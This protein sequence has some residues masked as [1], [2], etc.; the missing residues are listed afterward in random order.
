VADPHL[1]VA[2]TRDPRQVRLPDGSLRTPPPDWEFLPAGDAGL[3]RRVKKAGPVWVVQERHGRRLIARG[4]WAPAA[5]VAIARAE[6][7]LERSTPAYA[8][9]LARAAERRDREQSAYVEEFAAEVRRFLAFA[10]GFGDH[11][12]RLAEAVTRHATPV[13]SGTVARTKR[14]GVERRAE[15]AVIAWLRHRTTAYDHM[16]IARVKGMRREVRRRL[17]RA[18]RELL[19]RHRRPGAHGHGPCPLCAALAK[20][21]G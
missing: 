7:E 14:I 17:A 3:T 9:R 12:R 10:T 4:V 2:P 21:A 20:L 1:T 13:G 19:D 11:E 6:L 15:A 16:T 8:K 18:S 5:A